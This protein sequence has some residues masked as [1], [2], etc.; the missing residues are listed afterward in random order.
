VWVLFLNTN[1]TVK[2]YRQI[3]AENGG[4]TGKLDA[5][6]FFGQTLCALGD[7]NGDGIGDVAV[8]AIGDDDGGLDQGGLWFLYLYGP[9]WGDECEPSLGMQ[10]Y[11]K[12]A[13]ESSLQPGAPFVLL[14]EKAA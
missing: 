11:P 12:L 10:G 9:N 2:S 14:L 5:G 8:G 6:D 3:D 13:A 1:G 7:L 4:F